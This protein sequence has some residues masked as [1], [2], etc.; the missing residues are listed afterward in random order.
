MKHHS[1]CAFAELVTKIPISWDT[2]DPAHMQNDHRPTY[3][4]LPRR[5]LLLVGDQQ[6]FQVIRGA[7]LPQLILDA[8]D[9]LCLLLW[10]KPISLA[11]G[12]QSLLNT[13]VMQH[14][15]ERQE[16]AASPQGEP[17]VL[18]KQ[19]DQVFKATC[20]RFQYGYICT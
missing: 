20:F 16:P 3:C 13:P 5:H 9:Q 1:Q 19:L 14:G 12:R 17:H 6:L 15:E 2:E 8:P 4:I 7:D 18:S 11:T 10:T